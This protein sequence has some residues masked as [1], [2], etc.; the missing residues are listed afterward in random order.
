MEL[1]DI[2]IFIE[3]YHNRSIS[4]TAEKLNYTQSN[5][6]TRLMKLERVSYTTIFRANRTPIPS[7]TE[8]FY[9]YAINIQNSLDELYQEFT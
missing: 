7:D 6:S 4:R 1:N 5:V 9:H 2:K 8:R 3:L